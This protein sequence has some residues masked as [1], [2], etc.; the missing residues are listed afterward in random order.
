MIS[1]HSFWRHT[2]QYAFAALISFAC[3]ATAGAAAFELPA[4]NAP[5]S[6]EHHVGKVVWAD[7]VTPDLAAAEKFYGTLF[8]WTFQKI[9]AGDLD[10][11]VATVDGRPIGGLVEK[12]IP[13]G[14]QRQSAWLTFIAVRDVDAVKRIALA[15]GAKVLAD[16]KSYP[17]RGRK[18]VFSDPEGAVFAVLASSSGDA[19]DFLAT[20]GEWIWSSLHAKNVGAEAAFYQELFGYDVYDAPSDDGLEHLILSTDDY[21]RASANAHADGSA[22]RHSHWL[23]FVR[24]DNAAEMAAK[25]AG[26]GGKILV[27]PHVDRHGGML[28]VVADPG[29]APFGLMEWSDSDTKVEPK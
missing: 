8:G 18:C 19:P 7:L 15:H 1:S 20:P 3:A 11:A 6:T 22:R 29:G 12:S 17:S 9:R 14:E 2:R 25:V 10:Y 21:A 13:A 4:L 24:V 26:M 23:N 27:A 28:A 5:P 16:S